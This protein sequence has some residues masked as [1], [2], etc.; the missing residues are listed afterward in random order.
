MYTIIGYDKDNDVFVEYGEFEVL[1]YAMRKA[2]ELKKLLDKEELK[3]EN[4]EPIDWIEIYWNYNK[5]DEEMT[6][7][8][9]DN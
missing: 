9:Y 7:A 6:W 2:N 4:G 1:H 5:T 8:S 3:R